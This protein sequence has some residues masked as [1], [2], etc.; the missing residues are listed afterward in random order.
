MITSG[1]GHGYFSVEKFRDPGSAPVALE[2]TP[3]QR[4]LS[5]LQNAMAEG[6]G[7]PYLPVGKLADPS[8]PPVGAPLFKS[9]PAPSHTATQWLHGMVGA[10][11]LEPPTYSV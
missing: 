8:S 11:G 7:H 10:E 9:L 6:L 3:Q 2:F 4:G 5:S 1:L